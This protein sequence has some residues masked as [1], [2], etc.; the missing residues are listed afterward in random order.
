MTQQHEDLRVLPGSPYQRFLIPLDYLP[1][2]HYEPRWGYSRPTHSEL[3]TLIR[4]NQ[5]SYRDIVNELRGLGT[6]LSAINVEFT[7]ERAPEAG[8]IGGPITALDLA[9]L[10][11][12]VFKYQPRTYIEIGSGCTTC[13][14]RR[15]V[16]DHALPTR[17]VSIDP[18]PRSGI[19]SICDEVIRDGLET[20]T[21]LGLFQALQPGDIVFVDGSHRSFM[22]SDVTVFMLDVLPKLKPGVLVHFHDVFIPYD[23]PEMFKDWYWNEQYLLAAYL[24]A[25]DDRVRILMPSYYLSMTPGL[26]DCLRPPIVEIA[27][28]DQEWLFGGSLWFTRTGQLSVPGPDPDVP[29]V[30]IRLNRPASPLNEPRLSQSVEDRRVSVITG[31]PIAYDSPDHMVPWGT[32]QDNSV[33]LL[34]NAKLAAWIPRQDLSVLD[35]GCAGGGFVK[36]LLDTDCFAVGIEGSDYSKLNRRAEWATIPNRLFTADVTD[37]FQIVLER[38]GEDLWRRMRFTVI[39]AWELMEHIRTDKIPVVFRNIH[40]NL[41]DAGVVIMSISP[42]E[43]VIEGV[44]LHQT[45]QDKS[46]WIA[47]CRRHG[48]VNHEERVEYFGDDWVR[49]GSNAP[50]SF[51]LVLTRANQPLPFIGRA[52]QPTG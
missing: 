2:R 3:T 15:A 41:R 6:Y 30:E 32:K 47:E 26:S 19:D 1:S 13:M 44:A 43:E 16:G 7:N 36:S 35:L 21:D 22:N 52:M 18:D 25:A 23:Y 33:N 28:H 50:G 9:L 48:F 39:T 42:N 24:L 14:T 29:Q 38:D 40:D 45:V 10:Y 4:R 49:G 34:F 31:K 8:W 5:D 37:P 27:G 11:Y 51:H 12:F 20:V 17:I 46:W